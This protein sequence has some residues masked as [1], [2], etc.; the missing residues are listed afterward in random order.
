[1]KAIVLGAG[2]YTGMLLVR[3]LAR[4]PRVESVVAAARSVAG[5]PIGE[6][7]PGMSADATARVEPVV[8]DIAAALRE[9]ADVVFSALPHQASAEVVEPAIGR[10]CVI[11]LSADFRF[12]DEALYRR[13]YDAPR[14]IASVQDRAVYGLSEWYRDSQRR[15]DRKSRVFSFRGAVGS[16]AG[17]A[18][19]TVHRNDRDQRAE[20][21]HRRRQASAGRQ[22]VRRADREHERIPA[23][24]L[25]PSR[26]RVGRAVGERGSVVRAAP[27]SRKAGRVGHDRDSVP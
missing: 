20:R 11:D 6:V 23:G 9:P 4:H 18:H 10:S 22:S 19:G 3:I 1:M 21:N 12:R 14:P 5:R 8:R 7:D 24:P 16:A 26:S 27:R 15:R 2:G 25:A 17:G 13:A